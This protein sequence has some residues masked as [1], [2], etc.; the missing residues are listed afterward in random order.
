MLNMECDGSAAILHATSKDEEEAMLD[1]PANAKAGTWTR[2]RLVTSVAIVAGLAVV[3]AAS[4]MVLSQTRGPMQASTN[5]I[6]KLYTAEQVCYAYT[7]GTCNTQD[8]APERR[9]SC[10]NR[11]C[12]CTAGCSAPNGTCYA[13]LTNLAVASAISLLNVRWPSYAMYVQATSVFGQLKTTSAPSWMNMDQDIFTIWKLPG[14][15]NG[16]PKFFLGSNRWAN[17]VARV[18]MTT[19]TA[20]STHGFYSSELT[21]DYAPDDIALTICRRSTGALMLGDSSSSPRWAYVHSG[22]WFV[23]ATSSDP[24]EGG[25]WNPDPPIPAGILPS[26][27]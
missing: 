19:G 10:V 14:Q 25:Y 16:Q 4:L 24:G 6:Q 17:S 7:G 11:D 3:A 12:V 2:R 23:Y 5:G 27:P 26:C 18:A 9:A 8:C 20:F 21:N 13:G 1:T 15:L 22:S